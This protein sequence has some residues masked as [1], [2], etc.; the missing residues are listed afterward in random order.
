MVCF[1]CF[2]PEIWTWC[3]RSIKETTG[4]NWLKHFQST[5][6]VN[7]LVVSLQVDT[8]QSTEN[9]RRNHSGCL[10]CCYHGRD[11]CARHSWGTQYAFM[12]LKAQIDIQ[13]PIHCLKYPLIKFFFIYIEKTFDYFEMLT[14]LQIFFFCRTIGFRMALEL[15]VMY[16]TDYYRFFFT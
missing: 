2:L 7:L 11:P 9:C 3:R 10:C 13:R 1:V 12:Q 6:K 14:L 4:K 5:V 15:K 16:R 8:N